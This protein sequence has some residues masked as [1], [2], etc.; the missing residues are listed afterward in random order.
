MCA[1]HATVFV[2]L[3]CYQMISN[4]LQQPATTIAAY[5]VLVQNVFQIS[6]FVEAMKCR[7]RSNYIK[8]ECVFFQVSV[9]CKVNI[10]FESLAFFAYCFPLLLLSLSASSMAPNS[11]T[12]KILERRKK[13]TNE[14]GKRRECM[15]QWH[16]RKKSIAYIWITCAKLFC[17]DE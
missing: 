9:N 4:R 3:E 1:Y 10:S 11:F 2:S 13:I 6:L 15:V 17:I 12:A 14:W 8:T 7:I 16:C 5:R